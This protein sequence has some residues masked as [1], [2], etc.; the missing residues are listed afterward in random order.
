[1]SGWLAIA[2][3]LP[4]GVLQMGE[5]QAPAKAQISICGGKYMAGDAIK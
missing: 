2:A 1:L 4:R 3:A 5:Q